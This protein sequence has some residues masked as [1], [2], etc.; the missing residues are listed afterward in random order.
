MDT[1]EI[2]AQLDPAQK[3]DL[4]A[5]LGAF[6]QN[7]AKDF[8]QDPIAYSTIS[9]ALHLKGNIYLHVTVSL[10]MGDKDVV[11]PVI[12]DI[13]RLDSLDAYLEALNKPPAPKIK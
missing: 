3:K 1:D 10:H 7:A 11:H 6:A 2:L 13:Q 5:D 4:Y 8:K 12:E 9:T